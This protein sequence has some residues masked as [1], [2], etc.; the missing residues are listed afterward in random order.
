LN[1]GK[2]FAVGFVRL[3]EKIE[4]PWPSQGLPEHVQL[5]G[6]SFTRSRRWAFPYLGVVAQ[7]RED[8]DHGSLHLMVFSDGHYE[9]DHR[10]DANPERGF[11][12][13]HTMRD[14]AQ[15]SLGGVA[16]ALGV[17]A[18]ASAVAWLIGKVGRS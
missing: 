10:D 16:V 7:Y 15:T 3:T 18:L 8:V 13:E 4:G 12:V 1:E 14:V 2:Q 5:G 17:T 9:I 6:R 11:V